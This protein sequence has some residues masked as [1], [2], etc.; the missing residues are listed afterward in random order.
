MIQ[1]IL[2]A[3]NNWIDRRNAHDDA[4]LSASRRF[5]IAL[6]FARQTAPEDE[7]LEI[8]NAALTACDRGDLSGLKNATARLQEY[9]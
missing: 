5:N 6:T 9:L 8:C 4:L 2:K 1:Q 3:L 7:L